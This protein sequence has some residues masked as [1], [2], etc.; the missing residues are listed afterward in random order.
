MPCGFMVPCPCR[1]KALPVNLIGSNVVRP[2]AIV[3]YDVGRVERRLAR[4]ARPAGQ[5][6]AGDVEVRGDLV[7]K[8]KKR[9]QLAQV[10]LGDVSL[11]A[12]VK[13]AHVV[14]PAIELDPGIDLAPVGLPARDRARVFLE[15]GAADRQGRVVARRGIERDPAVFTQELAFQEVALHVIEPGHSLLDVK[16]RLDLR[17]LLAQQAHAL[18]LQ[19]SLEP[20]A[21][22]RWTSR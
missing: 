11:A 12:A 17:D 5:G 20:R 19:G 16:R 3:K 10:A 8:P 13:I 6:K 1:L 18:E 21:P 22:R 7:G 14:A 2:F 9:G 15:L 4:A